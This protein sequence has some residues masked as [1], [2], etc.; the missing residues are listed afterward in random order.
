LGEAALSAF[1]VPT[2]RL[3]LIDAGHF[4][5]EEA[6]TEYAAIILDSITGKL[7]TILR[8]SAKRSADGLR[9]R[10]WLTPFQESPNVGSC[11]AEKVRPPKDV[12]YAG[13]GVL[14]DGLTHEV[15]VWGRSPAHRRRGRGDSDA[16]VSGGEKP[17]VGV[18]KGPSTDLG[19]R[20]PAD[21]DA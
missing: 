7:V 6:P 12:R 16:E 9:R 5:W 8:T 14:G 19:A 17:P 3:A 20:H 21:N 15:P 18:T 10:R 1:E 4:V 13:D 2:H 11:N